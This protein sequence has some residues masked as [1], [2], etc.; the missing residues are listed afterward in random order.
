M[1]ETS[2]DCPRSFV[3]GKRSQIPG[4]MPVPS[5][6]FVSSNFPQAARQMLDR[7]YVC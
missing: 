6:A 4:G 2:R 3:Y 1:A 7:P 5:R